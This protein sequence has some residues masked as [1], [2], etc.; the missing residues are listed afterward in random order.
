LEHFEH[1]TVGLLVEAS[2]AT[3]EKE[4]RFAPAARLV[5]VDPNQKTLYPDAEGIRATG[6]DSQSGLSYRAIQAAALAAHRT[7][8]DASVIGVENLSSFDRE[9]YRID[10]WELPIPIESYL[11]RG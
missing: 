4:G 6:I 10:S 8:R 11:T 5:S 9:Y 7:Q 1:E 3:L 2:L